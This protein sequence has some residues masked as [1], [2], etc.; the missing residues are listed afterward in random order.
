M[1]DCA[2]QKM[3]KE[4]KADN[5]VCPYCGKVF[6]QKSYRDCHVKNQ[7]EDSD[8][9]HTFADEIFDDGTV[10]P[11]TFV[12]E[13]DQ[14]DQPRPS[15]LS[16][17]TYASDIESTPNQTTE[18]L[19]VSFISNDGNI[20][21]TWMTEIES[22]APVYE[23]FEQPFTIP[24]SPVHEANHDN[25]LSESN[26]LSNVNLELAEE[27]IRIAEKCENT[28]EKTFKKRVLLKIKSDLRNWFYKQSATKFLHET[29]GTEMI[30]DNNFLSWLA[31]HLD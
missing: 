19:N 24:T 21:E 8:F 20:V 18:L 14:N 7:H 28:F 11:V 3:R 29:F 25:E 17:N 10:V 2:K 31:K 1:K 23:V 6:V 13:F 27:L 22:E 15:N 9:S 30:H 5:K 4:Q 16:P 26:K 12:P